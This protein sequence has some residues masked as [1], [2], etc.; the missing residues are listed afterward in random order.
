MIT[1]LTC[2]RLPFTPPRLQRSNRGAACG[3]HPPPVN[4]SQ[5]KG[6]N[7][8]TMASYPQPTHHPVSEGGDVQ[9]G[10]GRQWGIPPTMDSTVTATPSF[11]TAQPTPCMTQSCFLFAVLCWS[12]L[13]HHYTNARDFT[14]SETDYVGNNPFLIGCCP[15]PLDYPPIV[16]VAMFV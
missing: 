15:P 16:C 2:H 12:T 3:Y 10:Q 1:E 4:N 13:V 14:V 8:S 9:T 7:A 5:S 6:N 11:A